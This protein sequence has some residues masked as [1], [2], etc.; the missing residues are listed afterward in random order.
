MCGRGVTAAAVCNGAAAEGI[1]QIVA[2]STIDAVS[3]SST[4]AEVATKAYVGNRH[5][6]GLGL[7]LRVRARFKGQGYR[8]RVRDNG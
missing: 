7:G 6:L 3:S 5:E 2:N 4:A 1:V 8:V